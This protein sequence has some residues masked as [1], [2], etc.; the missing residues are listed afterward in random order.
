MHY[1][2]YFPLTPCICV[3]IYSFFYFF[4]SWRQACRRSCARLLISLLWLA[5]H[6]VRTRSRA[7]KLQLQHPTHTNCLTPPYLGLSRRLLNVNTYCGQHPKCAEHIV[8]MEDN[9]RPHGRLPPAHVKGGGGDCKNDRVLCFGC[10]FKK[11]KWSDVIRTSCGAFHS[12]LLPCDVNI[13][14]QSFPSLPVL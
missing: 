4:C 6:R 7:N 2:I 5:R 10:T 14:I 12:L 8:C 1:T 3:I 9:A 13:I 11:P